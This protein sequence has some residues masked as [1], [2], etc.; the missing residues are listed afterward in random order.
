MSTHFVD[1]DI[2]LTVTVGFDY[3]PAE[4]AETG[5]EAQYP[6]CPEEY[7]IFLVQLNGLDIINR[8]SDDELNEL[9]TQLV[10]LRKK[11]IANKE[12]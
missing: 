1:L 12:P 3:S 7:D 8:L 9:G 10:Y 4:P 2:T 6:G 5:P 11:L